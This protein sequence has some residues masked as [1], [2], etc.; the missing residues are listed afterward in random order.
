MLNFKSYGIET[1][2]DL[3]KYFNE[4]MKY[5]F[6]YRKKVY[7]DLESNFQE[8]FDKYYKLRI[9]EDFIKNKYGVCW[10]FC[11][12][13]RLYFEFSKIEHKCY[14]IECGEDG[15]THTFAIYK[16]KDKWLWFEYAWQKY[17]GTHQYNSLDN[18][19]KDIIKKFE[20]FCEIDK[21]NI[22]IYETEKI[23]TRANVFEFVK[24]CLKGKCVKI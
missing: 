15:P 5:G 22:N 24:H 6:V 21:N 1:P 19:L 2:E 20:S 18:A 12:L 11:E 13:E 9:G 3:M 23:K 16:S 10:D 17:R 4:N 7:T 8:N 14:F